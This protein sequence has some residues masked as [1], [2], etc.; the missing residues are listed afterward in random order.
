MKIETLSRGAFESALVHLDSGESFVSESG[1]MYRASTNVDIDV[2]TRSRG[3]GGVMAG[4]KRLLAG[5]KFFFST[6]TVTDGQPGEV[7][8]SATLPGQVRVVEVDGSAPWLCTGGSFLGASPELQIDTEFQGMKGF[9]SGE[10]ISV[11]R[12]SGDGSLIV[13]AFGQIREIE[14]QE[15]LTVDTGH[16]VAYQ[17]SLDYEITKAGSG[18]LHTFLAG[19]GF[20]MRF[21]GQGRLLVQSHNPRGYGGALGPIL[22]ARNS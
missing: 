17:D 11:L 19:E 10:S 15:G 22:P 4:L 18:W 1:A 20:V 21:R 8:L 2:T 5:E 7:G 6:Y 16:L 14:V 12:V 3:K 13:G 9:L